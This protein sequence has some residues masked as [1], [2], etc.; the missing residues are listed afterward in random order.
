MA[1]G[2][3]QLRKCESKS[4]KFKPMKLRGSC[5]SFVLRHQHQTTS[6]RYLLLNTTLRVVNQTNCNALC[7]L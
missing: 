7:Y 5:S 3:N 2:I 4:L 6:R 1:T